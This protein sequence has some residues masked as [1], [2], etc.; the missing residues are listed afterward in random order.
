MY[1]DLVAKSVH[2]KKAELTVRLMLPRNTDGSI[3]SN[4]AFSNSEYG[5]G[6]G[7]GDHFNNQAAEYDRVFNALRENGI[8]DIQTA[9]TEWNEQDQAKGG[10]EPTGASFYANYLNTLKNKGYGWFYFN[11][12]PNYP[13][14]IKDM[15]YNDKWNSTKTM[16]YKQ[17][18][19]DAL[20]I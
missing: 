8:A 17:M 19:V 12:D 16:T 7:F 13:W 11:Y 10:I 9:I 2:Y 5:R 18:L 6:G 14:T 20:P 1:P 15:N 3:I 4:I